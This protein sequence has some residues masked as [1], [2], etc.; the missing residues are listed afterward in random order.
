MTHDRYVYPFVAFNKGRI[1]R[2]YIPII[3]INPHKAINLN[4]IALLDTGADSCLFPKFV[5]DVTAHDLKNS[6]V[7]KDV[8]YGVAGIE[9][10]TWKHSFVIALLSPDRSK[11]VWQSEKTLIDCADHNDVSLILGN[12]DFLANFKVTFDYPKKE[13]I[14]EF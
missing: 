13:I 1:H 2:P 5:A 11:I 14:I 10:E 8:S 9:M 6:K 7:Q 3:V 12:L 4:Q